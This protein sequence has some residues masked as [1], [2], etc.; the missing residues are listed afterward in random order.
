MARTVELTTQLD[1]TPD[2]AWARVGSSDLLR[3]ITAP[4]IRFAP[5][6]PG[7]PRQWQ[8]G[9]YKAWMWLFG[10][11]PLGWQAIVISFPK[12]RNGTR[13]VRDNG[14]GPLIRRWDHWIEIAPGAR[15]GTTRYTDS[16]TIEVGFLAPLIAVF[17]RVFYTHRQKRWRRLARE[18]F[19]ALR[20]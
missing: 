16:V 13:F 5:D 3:H 17:A 2:E 12:P 8:V 10:V 4:L 6:A 18:G 15:P 14:Y 20:C 9:E 11:I 19:A 7:F 1:C